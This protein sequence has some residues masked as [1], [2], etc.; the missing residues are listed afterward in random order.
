MSSS[1]FRSF[2]IIAVSALT[3]MG[4]AAETPAPTALR[5]PA[6]FGD[7]MVLQEGKVLRVWGW[8]PPSHAV[9]VR[10]EGQEKTATA[11]SGGKWMVKLSP[12][13]PGRSLEMAVTGG[14][15][16]T[17]KNILV[18]EVWLCAGQSNMELPM[19]P[20]IADG[21]AEIRAA[22]YPEIR[23]FVTKTHAP[24]KPAE[25]CEG[26]WVACSPETVPE[27]SAAGYFFGRKLHQELKVPVGLIESAVGSTPAENWISYPALKSEPSL[28]P[29]VDHFDTIP[30]DPK[31]WDVQLA[32]GLYN[33]EI[34]PL[35]PLAIRGVIWYQGESNANRP[36]QYRT[37]F[38]L[39]IR[40]WRRGLGEDLPFYFVQLAN[41]GP[42]SSQP[43]DSAR[44][45]LREAQSLALALPHT[46]MAVAIDIGEADTIHPKDK[47]DVGLR[48]ALWALAKTYGEKVAY[49]GPLYKTM[50][51]EGGKI[52]LGFD[53]I[54]GGMEAKGGPLK[55]FAI[56]GE[57]KKFVWAD[58]VVDGGAVL[59]SSP[60]VAH[61]VAV[62]YAWADNPAGCNLSNKADLPASPFRTDTWVGI[63]DNAQ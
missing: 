49:S 18:G 37:L 50:T 4:N 30:K 31:G 52:R 39:L 2:V 7:N 13:K 35:M 43:D 12:L 61:P 27:F 14:S 34:A 24:A 1:L 6:I 5:L 17:F 44:A 48:L 40:D 23:L 54:D 51:V 11:D 57:D 20:L 3:N 56:A 25:D 58:A 22:N 32:T 53:Q 36:H 45:Q 60:R 10:I 19:G 46:G 55:G 15:T 41:F 59:V 28:K 42:V 29:I 26:Q 62:R 9:T 63:T 33:G 21:A 8:A 38:P 16:I 47:Q